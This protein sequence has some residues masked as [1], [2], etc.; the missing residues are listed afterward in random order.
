MD[1]HKLTYIHYKLECLL[2][3]QETLENIISGKE[4][5]DDCLETI[6]KR[7]EYYKKQLEIQKLVPE[8]ESGYRSPLISE[9]VL[10]LPIEV[11]I[12]SGLVPYQN[13]EQ[14]QV[15]K[16]T[17]VQEGDLFFDQEKVNLYIRVKE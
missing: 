8:K 4:S 13:Y 15:W 5:A 11:H 2:E 16:K 7:I 17:T 9:L 1:M 14:G 3:T 6:N 12:Q 10:G